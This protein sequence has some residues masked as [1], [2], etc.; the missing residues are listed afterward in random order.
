M[1]VSCGLIEIRTKQN[2]AM[3]SYFGFDMINK[4]QTNP[5]RIKGVIWPKTKASIV[6]TKLNANNNGSRCFDD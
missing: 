1:M 5:N 3:I 6:D 2:P 4:K